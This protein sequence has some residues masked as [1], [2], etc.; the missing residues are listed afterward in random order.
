MTTAR[1]A[2]APV[3][4]LGAAVLFG[5]TGTARALGPEISPLGVG[6]ARIAVGAV[7]LAAFAALLARSERSAGK[8]RRGGAERCAPHAGPAA[9]SRPTASRPRI[10]R[11][12]VL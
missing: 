6:A 12:P 2:S 1:P 11:I 10:P 8:D 7:L 9:A 3:L 5:T 4:V